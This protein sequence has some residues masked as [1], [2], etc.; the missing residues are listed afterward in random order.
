MPVGLFCLEVAKQYNTARGR[1]KHGKEQ[2]KPP[3]ASGSETLHN[4]NLLH[5]LRA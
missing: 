2:R 1:D 5:C 3:E 4:T